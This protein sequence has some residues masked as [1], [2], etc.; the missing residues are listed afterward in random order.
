VWT[1]RTHSQTALA[2]FTQKTAEAVPP[3]DV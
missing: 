1:A 3:R 2:V